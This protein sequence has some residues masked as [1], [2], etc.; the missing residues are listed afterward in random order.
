MDEWILRLQQDLAG[1][2]NQQDMVPGCAFQYPVS[3]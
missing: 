1:D 3:V 2:K